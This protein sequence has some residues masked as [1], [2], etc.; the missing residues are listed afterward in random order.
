MRQF[1]QL[2]RIT[3]FRILFLY[4]VS[5]VS[6]QRGTRDEYSLHPSTLPFLLGKKGF[7]NDSL[8]HLE[9]YTS[10]NLSGVCPAKP[11]YS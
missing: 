8:L 1:G 11:I 2:P 10:W 5:T 6:N 9:L 4:G 7:S 3:P